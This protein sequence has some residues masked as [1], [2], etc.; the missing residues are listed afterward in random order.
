[1]LELSNG[2][3]HHHAGETECAD[4]TLRMPRSALEGNRAPVQSLIASLDT[5]EFWFPIATP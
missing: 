5:F 3:L 1:M 4:A 2:T